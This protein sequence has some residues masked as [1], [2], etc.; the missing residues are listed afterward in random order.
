MLSEKYADAISRG[1]ELL[2]TAN[3]YISG[4]TLQQLCAETY[5]SFGLERWGDRYDIA[6]GGGYIGIRSPKH[7]EKG[8]IFY[9][10]LYSLFPFDNNICICS[11]SGRNLLNRFINTSN[12][13]YFIALN[14]DL[15]VNDIDPNATYYVIVDMYSALYAPNRLTVVEVCEEEIYARDLLAQYIKEGNPIR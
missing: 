2:G 13:N 9:R 8:D 1:D 7:L 12:S 5:L 14:D 10:D 6:L 4:K 3:G 15:R 11:I